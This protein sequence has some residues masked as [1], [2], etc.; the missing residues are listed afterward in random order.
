M[1]INTITA[2]YETG[3]GGIGSPFKSVRV[4]IY[5]VTPE[6]IE[7]SGGKVVSELGGWRDDYVA[8][9][10]YNYGQEYSWREMDRKQGLEVK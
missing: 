4:R 5:K 3:P 8:G 6:N 10:P 9:E 7:S 1:N 2:V